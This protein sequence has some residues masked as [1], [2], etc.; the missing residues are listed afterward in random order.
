MPNAFPLIDPFGRAI[1]YVRVSVTDRCDLRCIYC[2]PERQRFLPRPLVLTMEELQRLSEAFI[3]LGTR[4]LRITGGEPLVRRD[5]MTLVRGL[6]AHVGGGLDELTMTTNGSLLAAHADELASAGVRRI[7]VSLDTL[8]PH[9]YRVVTRGGR[10]E[11]ALD[12]IEAASRAG[13]AVKIN[14]VALRGINEDE[15]DALIR[16]CGE[17]GHD[18]CLIETMPM[19]AVEEDRTDRYLPLSA[20]RRTLEQRWTMRP[21]THRSGGPARYVDVEETGGRV[22]FIT[23][24]TH[25]FCEQCN[26]VRLSCTGMLFLCLGQEDSA[27]LRRVIRAGASDAELDGA[28]RSAIAQKPKG[29]DFVIARR[30]EPPSI[31]RHMSMTGG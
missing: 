4:R 27:D 14:T 28:I 3:R 15:Y 13:I 9:T 12:G 29:H 18:L 21:S 20:V 7:N 11:A 6:G 30:D 16:W 31:A 10:L 5:V 26:R 24:L 1:S 25:N 19:G 17:R 8:D 2:M 23:P 22:G